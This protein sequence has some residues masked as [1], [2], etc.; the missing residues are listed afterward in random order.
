MPITEVII[1]DGLLKHISNTKSAT[2]CY[3][4][5]TRLQID[6]I[7]YETGASAFG[8]PELKGF[9]ESFRY[10]SAN[11]FCAQ[12]INLLESRFLE[13]WEVFVKSI[14]SGSITHQIWSVWLCHPPFTP[15][16]AYFDLHITN[17]IVIGTSKRWQSSSA[18]SRRTQSSAAS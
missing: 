14:L 1:C 5:V 7:L 8:Q 6:G 15:H 13:K 17:C 18:V 10:Y 2:F 3:G 16:N 4:E 9:L 11:L 12:S